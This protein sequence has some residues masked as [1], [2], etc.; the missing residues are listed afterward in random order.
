M[1][2]RTSNSAI[3]LSHFFTSPFS[4][5]LSLSLSIPFSLTSYFSFFY[6]SLSLSLSLALA[7]LLSLVSLLLSLSIVL[8]YFD[9]TYFILFI[10]S[11]N[12]FIFLSTSL[13]LPDS[14]FASVSLSILSRLYFYSNMCKEKE[15]DT[16]CKFC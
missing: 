15:S 9:P 2:S 10:L 14:M 4:P 1:Q 6:I 8:L 12:S 3:F 13:A 11:I 7:L 16:A 5:S